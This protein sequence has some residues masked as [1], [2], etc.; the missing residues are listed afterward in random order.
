MGKHQRRT[1]P[2]GQVMREGKPIFFQETESH[3]SATVQGSS[4]SRRTPCGR[5][6]EKLTGSNLIKKFPPL[7]RTR[8]FITAFTR[9]HHLSLFWARS[10]QSTLTNPRLEDL[11]KYYIPIYA[12][13]FQVD[14]CFPTKTCI[15]L[16]SPPY[17]PYAL[18][19]LFFFVWSHEKYWVMNTQI[20]K[21]FITVMRHLTSG[22][23]SGKCVVRWFRRCANV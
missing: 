3:L 23:P 11:F 20:F 9:A 21:V 17:V 22:I 19:I 8:R 2:W 4:S 18:P 14:L 12:W 6:H 13:V 5:F 16:P 15:H 1:W 7:N 10:I